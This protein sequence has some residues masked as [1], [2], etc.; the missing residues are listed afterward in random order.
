MTT[1]Q[2]EAIENLI[3]EFDFEKAHAL[4]MIMGWRYFDSGIAPSIER[5]KQTAKE[6]LEAAVIDGTRRG[7]SSYFESGRF[8]ATYSPLD[9]ELELALVFDYS[10][11]YV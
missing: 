11:A 6:L 10:M 2:K 7:N 8:K 9:K 3:E 4:F 5:M 1:K